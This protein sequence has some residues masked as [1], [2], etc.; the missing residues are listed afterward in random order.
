MGP[1]FLMSDFNLPWKASQEASSTSW[2]IKAHSRSSSNFKLSRESWGV[3][4]TWSITAQCAVAVGPSLPICT[5][6]SLLVHHCTLCRHCWSITATCTVLSLL[7]HHCTLCHHCWA[8]AA[9]AEVADAALDRTHF[10]RPME[11]KVLYKILFYLMI[12]LTYKTLQSTHA[13]TQPVGP[14]RYYAANL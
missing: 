1:L 14:K 13:L 2:G 11:K 7:V 12:L 6:P 9:N 3:L 8:T 4:Q 10:L 5:V